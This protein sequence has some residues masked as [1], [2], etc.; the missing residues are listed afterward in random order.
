[1]I[2]LRRYYHPIQ[3]DNAAAFLRANGI[4]AAVVGDHIRDGFGG[5]APRFFGL[6]LVVPSDTD[7]A[8]A[9]RL[10]EEFDNVPIEVEDGWED[11]AMADLSKLDPSV[12]EVACPNC[13]VDLPL[14]SSLQQ[15][16][17]C[18]APVDVPAAIALKYGPD[19]LAP[20]FEDESVMGF[21][22][23]VRAASCD[24]CG[25]NLRGLAMRGRCPE[26]GS[27]YDVGGGRAE[28]IA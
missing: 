18:R 6:D 9:E 24:F 7:R 3:A 5:I 23:E 13:R 28:D 15:C 8:E 4:G 12:I 14:D 22:L 20:C 16:P 17:S 19:V 21:A 26:C 2:R 25:Y 27:L 10:L 1:M 11:A